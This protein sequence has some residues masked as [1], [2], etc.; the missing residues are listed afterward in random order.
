MQRGQIFLPVRGVFDFGTLIARGG[1]AP[2]WRSGGRTRRWL[3][4]PER[5]PDGSVRLVRICAEA[6]GVVLQVT[7]RAARE[8]E[9]L[10]PLAVRVRRAL[11]LD[12]RHPGG[13]AP[14]SRASY[15]VLRGTTAFEDLVGILVARDPGASPAVEPL[16][17]LVLLG[18][19]CP[20]DRRRH[21]FPTPEVL[22]RLSLR[23]LRRRTGLGP[24]A[25][26]VR[27]LA[28]D[29]A[30][31]TRDPRE[32]DDLPARDAVR[33][34]RGVEGLDAAGVRAMLRLL[35]HTDRSAPARSVVRRASTRG[36]RTR[37]AARS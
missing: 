12:T 13:G 27:T 34:L 25:G 15:R 21:A 11:G 17:A 6:G 26:W 33:A 18:S 32:L 36:T 24:A 30:R 22:A 3:E 23:E 4:R 8:I 5:L 31:G 10:A 16:H 9:T 20:A 7:G 14:R 28:R 2:P 1:Q 37:R 35:G 19:R 29:V